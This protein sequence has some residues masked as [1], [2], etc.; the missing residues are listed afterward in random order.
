MSIELRVISEDDWEAFRD[1]RLRA[2]SDAPDSFGQ[3]LAASAA[4]P[5]DV[6]RER[7]HAGGPVVLAFAEGRAVAMGGLLLPA[8]AAAGFVWGMWVEPAWRGQGLAG[9]MVRLLLDLAGSEGRP[10]L[11]HVAEGNEAARGLYESHGFVA[12]GDWQPLRD[13]SD[14][15]IE[16]MRWEPT[17]R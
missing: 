8:D 12:T 15:R 13:G 2:L 10:A 4:Q 9:R 6:W 17:P 16:T 14:V 7:A 1:V 11:L 3:T 5:D